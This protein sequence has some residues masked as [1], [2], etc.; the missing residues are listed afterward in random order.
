M[1]P[2]QSKQDF[3]ACSPVGEKNKDE[4][5]PMVEAEKST[6]T[7]R[8]L[9][10]NSL[11]MLLFLKDGW[12]NSC[13]PHLRNWTRHLFEKEEILLCRFCNLRMQGNQKANPV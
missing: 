4:S 5:F 7:T 1:S 13:D 9:Q 3:G 6:L 12:H 10:K 11:L 8:N 2:Q